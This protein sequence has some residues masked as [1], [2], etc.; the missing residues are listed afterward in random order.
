MELVGVILTYCIMYLAN[1][2]IKCWKLIMP[3]LYL[4][5]GDYVLI[6]VDFGI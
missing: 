5:F 1:I 4:Y 6:I 2:V 3:S